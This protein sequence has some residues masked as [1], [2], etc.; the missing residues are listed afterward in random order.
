MGLCSSRLPDQNPQIYFHMHRLNSPEKGREPPP[1]TATAA[2]PIP[3]IEAVS[4]PTKHTIV[5]RITPRPNPDHRLDRT[6]QES[7]PATADRRG[8]PPPFPSISAT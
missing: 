4:D 6:P 3:A 2:A 1:A 8:P 7:G 5:L